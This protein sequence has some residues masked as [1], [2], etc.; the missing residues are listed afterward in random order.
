M[1]TYITMQ[2][3][4]PG[5][6]F[7]SLCCLFLIFSYK[8]SNLL[9]PN[10]PLPSLLPWCAIYQSRWPWT[11][12]NR[13]H[14]AFLIYLT[15][16][17]ILLMRDVSWVVWITAL[18][19]Q[20]ILKFGSGFAVLAIYSLWKSTHL[21]QKKKHVSERNI[22]QWK[23]KDSQ[24]I[25]VSWVILNIFSI[26]IFSISSVS[27]LPS[28]SMKHNYWTTDKC[29]ISVKKRGVFGSILQMTFWDLQDI[30]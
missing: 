18:E 10:H 14:P 23:V 1:H 4:Q 6:H 30:A 8:V 3:L 25:L 19:L 13:R 29:V 26:L 28:L 11:E 2:W 24:C 12:V 17:G 7:F 27:N 21:Y 20:V 15:G 22:S 9:V 16:K 5:A